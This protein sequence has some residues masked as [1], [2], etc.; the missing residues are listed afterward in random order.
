MDLGLADITRSDLRAFLEGERARLE[1]GVEAPP[2]N[3]ELRLRLLNRAIQGLDALD[4]G[5]VQPMFAPSGEHRWGTQPFKARNLQTAA[6][7]H[8]SVLQEMGL[9]VKD[10]IEKVAERY[11]YGNTPSTVTKWRK[12]AA[13]K[14]KSKGADLY[15]PD[16][17]AALVYRSAQKLG[18]APSKEEMLEAI[19]QDGKAFQEARAKKKPQK[20]AKS[21]PEEK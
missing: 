19:A 14:A 17:V 21:K 9:S 7:G 20:K 4:Y 6:V 18:W 16:R 11:G 15:A 2:H 13:K 8:V 12:E 3:Y 5:E 1:E 10:A